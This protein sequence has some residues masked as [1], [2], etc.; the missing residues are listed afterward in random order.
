MRE[1]EGPLLRPPGIGTWVYVNVPFDAAAAFGGKGQ[2]RVRGTVNGATF[3]SSLLPHGD[4]TH[5]LVVGSV[6]RAAAG[7]EVG[8]V[9][10]VALEADTEERTVD[11]PED[12]LAALEERP[13][14]LDFFTGLAYSYRKE[15][16]NWIESAKREQ[17]R[18]SRIAQAV[19][20]LAEGRKLR[21]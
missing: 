10:R 4:G 17:T 2:L 19:E 18:R 14:A 16:V 6:L 9:V 3:R 8:D 12:L 13:E 5:Y 20:R 11:V 21:S 15:Y 1:F 7:A